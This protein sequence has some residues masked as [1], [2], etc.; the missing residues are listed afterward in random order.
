MSA[1]E[2]TKHCLFCVQVDDKTYSKDKEKVSYCIEIN[3]EE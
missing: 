2:S 1:P 3:K